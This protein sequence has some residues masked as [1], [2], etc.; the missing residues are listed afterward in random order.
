[1]SRTALF[2]ARAEYR[3]QLRE[4]NVFERLGGHALRLGLISQADFSREMRKL[5]RRRRLIG[6][7]AKIKG[8]WQART[9]NLFQTAENARNDF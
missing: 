4:D 3:L 1:M 7:L 6:K 5:E 8:R 9:E 2:T